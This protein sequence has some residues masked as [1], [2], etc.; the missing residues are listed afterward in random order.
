MRCTCAVVRA[1][2]VY[3]RREKLGDATGASPRRR[4]S[5]APAAAHRARRPT[6]RYN[7]RVANRS[8]LSVWCR[9]FSESTSEF[10]SFTFQ[11]FLATV[12]LS[13]RRPG[14]TQLTIRAVSF[15][16]PPILELDLR[17]SPLD[18]AEIVAAAGEML[19]PDVCYEVEA[20][21]NLWSY[22]AEKKE[23]RLG[24]QRLEIVCQ[25]EEYDEGA[26][27]ENGHFCVD[28]G[29]EQLFTGEGDLLRNGESPIALPG[30]APAG[31]E[32]PAEREFL[33][34]LAQPGRLREYEEK[35]RENIRLL[36]NWIRRLM[37]DLPVERVRLWS[38]G[39]ENFEDRID[40]IQA[41]A[42]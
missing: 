21:W 40:A 19:Q 41:A 14:F 7:R 29:F 32:D 13:A 3:H 37:T 33:Q 8:Y 15:S 35:T 28:L 16:E 12:P 27:A 18:P 9:E 11:S 22:D 1:S 6:S 30:N 17:Q 39:E 4:S 42:G 36:Q 31:S 24:P 25:G 10:K 34:F 38:E 23:W 20:H 26:S 2:G 5:D